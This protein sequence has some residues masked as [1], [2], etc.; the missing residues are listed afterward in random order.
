MHFVVAVKI[1]KH[2]ATACNEMGTDGN[3]PIIIIIFFFIHKF[4]S[5]TSLKQNFRAAISCQQDVV[6]LVRH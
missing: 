1:Y 2:L 4:H 6:L 5:D 3:E